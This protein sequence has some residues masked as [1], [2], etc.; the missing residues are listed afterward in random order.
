MKRFASILLIFMLVFSVFTMMT[1]SAFAEEGA[2]DTNTGDTTDDTTGDSTDD[3][4]GGS[5]DD[6]TDDSTDDTTDD[7]TDDTTGGST[8]DTTDGET[9]DAGEEELSFTGKIL[10]FLKDME[11]QLFGVIDEILVFINSNE[12]YKNAATIALA[13]LAVLLLPVIIGLI[14]VIYV[15]V[16]AMILFAGALVAIIE[17]VIQTVAG[18]VPM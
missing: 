8:D 5:T 6:T 2:T 11:A 16:G 13:V 4:T 18:I 12:T 9:D 10:V 3:T 17:V 1:L 14:V 7:S 15:A